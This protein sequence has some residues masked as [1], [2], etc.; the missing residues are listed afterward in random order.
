MI[1]K[2]GDPITY[3]KIE[4]DSFSFTCDKCG[5]LMATCMDWAFNDDY[6][7]KE[8]MVEDMKMYCGRCNE[9]KN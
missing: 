8:H 1:R 9:E 4:L 7:I 6:Q 5:V 2:L 3:T